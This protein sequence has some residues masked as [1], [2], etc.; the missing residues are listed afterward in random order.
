MTRVSPTT[1][2]AAPSL[3]VTG[4]PL[5]IDDVVAV[6][7]GSAMPSLDAGV[8]GRMAAT[9][10][11]VERAVSEDRVMYGITT[12]FGALANTRIASGDLAAMQ[13]ALVRSHAAG[14]GEPLNDDVVRALLL[15]RART[16]AAGISGVRVDLPERLLLLL[17]RGLLPVVPEQGS[18]GASGDLA[19]LAHLA[20]PLVGEGRLRRVGDSDMW[21]RPARELLDA[22]G[23]AP[24]ELQPKEGLSLINGTEPM[25]ARLALSVDQARLLVKVADL[26]CAMS[27]DGLLGTDRAYD[28]RVIDIRPHAGQLHV[29]DNLRRLLDG[30]GLLASHRH[31]LEHAVQDSYSLRCA[32]QVHGA[33]RD[34]LTHVTSVLSV[35][36][37][38]VVDNPVIVPTP[39][40][41]D[42][43]VMSTG[44][45]HGEP[46][47][48]SG[49]MLAIAIS[50]LASISER[51]TDRMLDPA[52]SRGLPPFLAPN[53]GTNSGYMLAQYTAA[54]LVSENKVLAHPSSVDTIPTSGNQEDH[55]S[56]GWTSMRKLRDTVR[57]VRSVLAV[58]LVCAAQ[59]I[60]LRADVAA[61]SPAVAAAHAVLREQVPAMNVD[62]E[63]A[64][65][66]HAV[67]E[68]LPALVAAAESV[69]G[70]LD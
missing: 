30:S 15:L 18:V 32:P 5:T 68:L 4:D 12:G 62:R 66:I 27:L 46:L 10:A 14:V 53:A 24:L 65:Q 41:S 64:P 58:E 50:E 39:D 2:A 25:Q 7:R 59:A 42:Y 55:V 52:F 43:E 40:G 57:N 70:P 16:L 34:V 11:V 36:L 44:N 61:P 23:I 60:D 63:V 48:F 22:E 51:R 20:L 1:T 54:S 35:E 29:A 49:D 45:F 8:A 69:A 13:L 67:D 33:V 9:R 26:A 56:M 28:A 19:Q 21:G 3:V 47:A 31:D 37:G 6:A 17:Q 38:S